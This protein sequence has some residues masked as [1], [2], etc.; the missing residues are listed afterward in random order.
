MSLADYRSILSQF[1]DIRSVNLVGKGETLM[2]R[3]IK[4]IL[5]LHRERNLTTII[6]TNGH[7]LTPE[8]T[9][10][11]VPGSAIQVSIDSPDA[12]RYR[13]FRGADLPHVLGKTRE[14]I[15]ARPKDVTWAVNT[16]VVND[17]LQDLTPTIEL[18]AELGC[19]GVSFFLPMLFSSDRESLHPYEQRALFDSA[20][21][22]AS[23]L[24][25]KKRIN[26]VCKRRAGFRPGGCP[27][28]WHTPRISVSGDVY[29]CTYVY[30]ANE[31]WHTFRWAGRDLPVPQGNY[32]M[33]NLLA[34][35]DITALWTCEKYRAVRRQV[36]SLEHANN[37]PDHNELLET[38][39]GDTS[40]FK[41][42]DVC[43]YR[44]GIHC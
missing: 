44:H 39:L 27:E 1:P 33:G 30:V 40:G 14:A 26:L 35:D 23:A 32:V 15:R 21:N 12:D 16:V 17:N 41:F 2:H 13:R 29:P 22:A 7:L 34:G 3:D 9:S 19:H 8:I 37:R 20:L 24:A 18:A 42:C 31:D 6:V 10:L 4:G 5:S 36:L 43:M 38:Y 25:A 11:L 28:P